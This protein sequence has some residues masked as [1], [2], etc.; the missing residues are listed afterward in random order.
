MNAKIVLGVRVA[1]CVGA[2]GTLAG[3]AWAAHACTACHP[4]SPTLCGERER[5]D[6]DGCG[7][8]FGSNNGVLWVQA[9]CVPI[10]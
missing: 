5:K 1:A 7:M 3:V 10:E 4:A 9:I 8:A 6:T 2:L